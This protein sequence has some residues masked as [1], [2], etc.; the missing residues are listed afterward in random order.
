MDAPDW[1]DASWNRRN[2]NNIVSSVP[3][4]KSL[5]LA[6]VSFPLPFDADVFYQQVVIPAGA[7]NIEVET[8]FPTTGDDNTAIVWSGF[9]V[10]ASGI[11]GQSNGGGIEQTTVGTQRSTYFRNNV[12]FYA[13]AADPTPTICRSAWPMDDDRRCPAIIHHFLDDSGSYFN[14]NAYNNNGMALI[15]TRDFGLWV[16]RMTADGSTYTIDVTLRLKV[17]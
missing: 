15:P 8:Q 5:I 7:T 3:G 1:D 16:N 4:G 11:F 6:D 14:V 13:G 9:A 2:V 17:T 10:D 12:V